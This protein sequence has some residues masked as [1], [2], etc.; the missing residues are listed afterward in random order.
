MKYEIKDHLFWY[1]DLP[2]THTLF[3]CPIIPLHSTRV[4]GENRGGE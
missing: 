4:G 1:L 2:E 3:P